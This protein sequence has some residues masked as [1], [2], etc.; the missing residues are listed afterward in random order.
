LYNLV[1]DALSLPLFYAALDGVLSDQL[2]AELVNHIFVAYNKIIV[3]PIDVNPVIKVPL[4]IHH[5]N[6]QLCIDST[7][8]GSILVAGVANEN[9]ER[10]VTDN[11]NL[12]HYYFEGLV[13]QQQ[14]IWQQKAS[15]NLELNSTIEHLHA[16]VNNNMKVMNRNINKFLVKPP[17]MAT[18]QKLQQA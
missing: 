9:V 4:I 7:V 1:A 3:L 13:I 8:S 18:Q 11:F 15:L 6:D 17:C 16:S 2:P 10:S 14:H 5:L 12:D